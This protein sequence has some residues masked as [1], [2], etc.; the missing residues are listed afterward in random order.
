MATK[1]DLKTFR[2]HVSAHYTHTIE[3]TSREKAI[4][5]AWDDFD[6]GFTYGWKSFEDF[7]NNVKVEEV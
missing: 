5:M 7:K 3:T 1:K 6:G 4:Q 2:V